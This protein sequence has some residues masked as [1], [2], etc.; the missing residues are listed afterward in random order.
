MFAGG[1][2]EG[3][4]SRPLATSHI[5][6]MA[7]GYECA[8]AEGF[9]AILDQSPMVGQ[10]SLVERD[11]QSVPHLLPPGAQCQELPPAKIMEQ[12]SSRLIL[13]F[14][15]PDQGMDGCVP[16]ESKVSPKPDLERGLSLESGRGFKDV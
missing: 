8:T 9:L 10:F 13:K 11:S 3:A 1:R 14:C 7:R 6:S 16:I 12:I 2:A 4:F 5:L 15:L